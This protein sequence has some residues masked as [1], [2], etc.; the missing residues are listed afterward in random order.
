MLMQAP[1]LEKPFFMLNLAE[2]E[3]RPTNKSQ[4]TNNSQFFLANHNMKISL[5]INMKMPY[6]HFHIYQQRKFHAQLSLVWKK[7]YNLGAW[8]E[9]FSGPTCPMVIFVHVLKLRLIRTHS[10]SLRFIVSHKDSFSL[11]VAHCLT[12]GLILSHC[13]SLSRIRTHSLSLQLIVSH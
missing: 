13:E 4:I 8:C 12:L 11:I 2:H 10:L 1:R 5:L 7:F 9:V 3:I 6:L